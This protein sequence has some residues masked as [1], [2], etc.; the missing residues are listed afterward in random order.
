VPDYLASCDILVLARKNSQ[1]AQA[2]FPTK[3]GEYFAT[4][5]PVIMTNVGDITNYFT[6]GKELMI[7]EADNPDSVAKKIIYLIEH[8]EESVKI[9]KNGRKWAE[10]N[11]DYINNSKKILAFMSK[12]V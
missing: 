12:H 7:A 6:D 4:E 2:G 3:L 10:E 11:L 8:N 9:A 5:K 1:Y